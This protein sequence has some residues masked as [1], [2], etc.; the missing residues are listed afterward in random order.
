LSGNIN[1]AVTVIE[2]KEEKEDLEKNRGESGY[3]T[4][5]ASHYRSLHN[6]LSPVSWP[7]Q[8]WSG[9]FFDLFDLLFIYIYLFYFGTAGQACCPLSDIT[10]R[11][12]T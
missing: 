9:L 2:L 7:Q 12:Y 5:I 3:Q 11:G 6:F 10:R 1:Y 8:V 4:P